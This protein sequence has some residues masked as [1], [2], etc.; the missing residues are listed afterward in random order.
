MYFREVLNIPIH[1]LY[2]KFHKD[3]PLLRIYEEKK[4]ASTVKKFLLRPIKNLLVF[5]IKKKN[6]PFEHEISS[7]ET[8]ESNL[9][10]PNPIAY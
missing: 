10:L 4:I 6:F 2:L 3:F 9:H 5:R 8:A 1:G 7:L